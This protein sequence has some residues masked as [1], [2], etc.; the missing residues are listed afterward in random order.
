MDTKI[1]KI[2]I[3]CRPFSKVLTEK[4]PNME[5]A[6]IIDILCHA[7]CI[8]KHKG[9]IFTKKELDWDNIKYCISHWFDDELMEEKGLTRKEFKKLL[10]TKK[11]NK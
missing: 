5:M 11:E 9:G 4:F 7:G 10:K 1:Q 8:L 6:D 3:D 2:V